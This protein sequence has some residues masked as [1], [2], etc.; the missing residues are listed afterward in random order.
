MEAQTIKIALA[1]DHTLLR[2]ALA[3]VINKSGNLSVVIEA[4]TGNELIAKIRDETIPDIILLDLNMPELDGYET[5]LWLKINYPDIH[6]L[7]LTMYHTEQMMIRLLQAGVKGFLS[8]DT[9]ISE[10]RSAL[11]NVI[12]SGY[13]HTNNT[14]GRLINLFRKCHEQSTLMKNMLSDMEFRFLR[15]V[16]TDLTYK[17]IAK[18][19]HLNVRAID[20]IRDTLFDKL[21]VK[22]RVG[23]VMYSI[24]HGIQTF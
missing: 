15:W 7:M 12:K 14:T 23:L 24:R 19:M 1:D 5:A 11:N 20:N 18:E 8:K 10:L 4:G 16:C 3:S 6:V 2:S 22:S 17:E 9:E 21:E 13:H